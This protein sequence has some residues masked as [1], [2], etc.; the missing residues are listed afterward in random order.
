[1]KITVMVVMVVAAMSLPAEE[2]A[3]A[4]RPTVTVFVENHVGVPSSDLFA[5]KS[6]ARLMF[7]SAGVELRWRVGQPLPRDLDQRP[8]VVQIVSDAPTPGQP[9]ALAW[10]MPFEGVHIRILYGRIQGAAQPRIVLAYVL[11]HEITHMLQGIDHHSPTG[12]M[13]ARWNYLD[14]VE[15]Q[16]HQL[17][18]R[19]EDIEL[20]HLG[21]DARASGRVTVARAL[22]PASAPR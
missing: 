15:M 21:L 8:I 10:A 20:I 3:R 12:I 5:A 19:A 13:K 22:P 16:W 11:V 17:G 14:F 4:G 18:F 2:H 7:Q 1:M 6:M 9:H